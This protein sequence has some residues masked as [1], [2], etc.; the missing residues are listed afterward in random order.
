MAAQPC[1][2]I[3]LGRQA[4][5]PIGT[6]LTIRIVEAM[7]R[8]FAPSQP[9]GKKNSSPMDGAA[10]CDEAQ[11]AKCEDDLGQRL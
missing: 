10:G 1:L 6:K 9:R 11:A 4:R 8:G 7:L 5:S 2:P 3:Q